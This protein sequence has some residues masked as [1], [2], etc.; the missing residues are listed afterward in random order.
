MDDR[1]ERAVWRLAAMAASILDAPDAAFR[2]AVAE[3]CEGL[4]PEEAR[5]AQRRTAELARLEL[6]R[7]QGRRRWPIRPRAE[8]RR[9]RER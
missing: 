4:T 6:R 3:A 8:S 9:P 1:I 5:E 2:A 7:R